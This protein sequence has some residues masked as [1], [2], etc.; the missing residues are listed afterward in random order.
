MEDGIN[1]VDGQDG[2]DGIDGADGADGN[3]EIVSSD[4]IATEFST[5]EST[6]SSFE[7]FNFQ[8]TDDFMDTGIV[9][10]YGRS[11][12]NNNIWPIPYD[13]NTSRYDIRLEPGTPSSGSILNP[14]FVLGTAGTILFRG[15]SADGVDRTFTLF[16]E[17]RYIL[18]PGPSTSGK[19]SLNFEKMTYEEVMDHFNLD[20]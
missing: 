9:L 19:S 3:T 7:V 2:V 12:L 6:F 4:W 15:I 16:D 5:V 14:P 18:V 1:G 13:S 17:V 20:Y 11:N 8:L 10:A